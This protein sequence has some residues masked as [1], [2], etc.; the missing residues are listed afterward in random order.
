[1]HDVGTINHLRSE[2][3]TS[4]TMNAPRLTLR[5]LASIKPLS[6]LSRA[7]GTSALVNGPPPPGPDGS[8]SLF[9][10][11]MYGTEKGQEL[12]REMEQS[13]SKVLA[14]GKYVHKMNQ[15]HVKPDKINEYIALMFETLVEARLT[16]LVPIHSRRSRMIPKTTSIW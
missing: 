11:I 5:P 15:H 10:S 3:F 6:I 7:F 8:S 2:T 13:Y 4:L 1:M 12:Q 16:R 14:R 9:K